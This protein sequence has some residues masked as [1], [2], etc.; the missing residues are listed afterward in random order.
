MLRAIVTIVLSF[1]LVAGC[2]GG[3][4][5]ASQPGLV[6]GTIQ[7]DRLEPAAGQPPADRPPVA[8]ARPLEDLA[9][10]QE[11]PRNDRE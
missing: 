6:L 3:P 1:L 10:A 4:Q 8:A 7:L 2:A 5:Q 11:G 9:S